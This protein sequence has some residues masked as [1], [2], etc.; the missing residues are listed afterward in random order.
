MVDFIFAYRSMNNCVHKE[1]KKIWFPMEQIF[2]FKVASS[3]IWLYSFVSSQW[4]DLKVCF[5]GIIR[6][7]V[8]DKSVD[9][10]SIFR[11]D[12]AVRD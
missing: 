7:T 11:Y 6:G 3:I 12:P 1:Y 5:N 2:F 10:E 4:G 8:Q 9:M